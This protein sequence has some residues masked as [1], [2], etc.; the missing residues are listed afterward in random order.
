M[1]ARGRK[2]RRTDGG[3][4]RHGRDVMQ[5]E[6][7]DEEGEAAEVGCKALP[8]GEALCGSTLR[9]LAS[10]APPVSSHHRGLF[11]LL[12]PRHG[13]P[14]RALELPLRSPLL[15]LHLRPFK[16]SH[17]SHPH[18]HPTFPCLTFRSAT[19]SILAVPLE[20]E[21][22]SNATKPHPCRRCSQCEVVAAL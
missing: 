6:H 2:V 21:N 1:C 5:S 10:A 16:L 17:H 18:R 8:V 15:F 7:G 13:S 11:A 19:P 12:R 3:G 20:N 4:G 14:S 9:A 22:H